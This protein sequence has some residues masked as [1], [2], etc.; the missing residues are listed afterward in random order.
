MDVEVDEAEQSAETVKTTKAEHAADE[1]P[2]K[3][4]GDGNA[5]QWKML[6]ENIAALRRTIEQAVSHWMAISKTP[7]TE[8]GSPATADRWSG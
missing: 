6:N 5:R 7:T 1:T 8:H 4:R 2:V 3:D